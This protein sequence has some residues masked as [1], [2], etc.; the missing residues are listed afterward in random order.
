M[1][2]Y[3]EAGIQEAK[4]EENEYFTVRLRIYII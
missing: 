2:F 3:T 1:T 4:P